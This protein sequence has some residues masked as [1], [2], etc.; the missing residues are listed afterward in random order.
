MGLRRELCD[1]VSVG[2]ETLKDFDR[3]GIHSVG[4]LARCD[5]TKLYSKLCKITEVRHDPCVL[6]VFSCAIAQARNRNLPREQ[7]QWWYWSRRRKLEHAKK[8]R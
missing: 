3:L 2:R 8:F 6:D 4:Q 7:C 5:A 1:L